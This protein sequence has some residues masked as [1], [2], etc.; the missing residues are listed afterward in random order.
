L[1]AAESLA[2]IQ[3]QGLLD[4]AREMASTTTEPVSLAKLIAVRLLGQHTGDETI[5][6]LESLLKD[7]SSVVQSETLG[8]LFELDPKRVDAVAE[9][10]SQSPDVNVRT[11]CVNAMLTVKSP[12]RIV[13]LAHMLDDVNPTLRRQV[14]AGLIELAADKDLRDSIIEHAMNMTKEE[15]WRG[16]E[17]AAVVLAKLD[18]E[19]AGE[20]FVQLLKAQR[21]EVK[22]AA[23][24]GLTQLELEALCPDMLE[25]AQEVYE[26]FRSRR[27]LD[28]M[29][30]AS[31]QV[32]H[33]FTALG[34]LRYKEAEPLFRE[35]LP[36]QPYLGRESRAAAG[37]AIGL[38]HENDPQPDLVKIL[39]ER[40]NDA[41]S[42]EPEDEMMR[43]MCAL[44]L[45]R[46]NA[47]DAIPSLERYTLP[48]AGQACG[49]ALEKLTGRKPPELPKSVYEESGWFLT[50]LP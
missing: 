23:A 25:H 5:S 21:P 3:S 37:W 1:A 2:R 6:L 18:H 7:P 22:V 13:R 49:W 47:Q 24:W 36:K 29:R 20:R 11:H 30:G 32:A 4:M 17:Q 9:S 16:C 14:S 42:M 43:Q 28:S 27:L 50:P 41:N 12:G 48:G 35:Y 38:L 34:T 40:L 33:L 15:A 19:P 46:M 31:L 39:L 8:R 45:G 10:F 44:S 26:G